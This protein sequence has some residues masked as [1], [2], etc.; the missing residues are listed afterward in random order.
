MAFN[1]E[2]VELEEEQIEE[3]FELLDRKNIPTLIIGDQLGILERDNRDYLEV[4]PPELIPYL[5]KDY[6][7]K[8]DE[9]RRVR[10]QFSQGAFKSTVSKITRLFRAPERI[11][12]KDRV[13][14][15]VGDQIFDAILDNISETGALIETRANLSILEQLDMTIHLEGELSKF[16]AFVV[17]SQKSLQDGS[18]DLTGFGLRFHFERRSDKR[19][20]KEFVSSRIVA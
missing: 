16:P 12:L 4:L 19:R 1:F 13:L 9:L 6:I 18:I 14:I 17:R 10:E 11:K 5:L 7:E 8:L 3:L 15:R 20:L 2:G